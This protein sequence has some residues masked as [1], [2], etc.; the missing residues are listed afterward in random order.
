MCFLLLLLFFYISFF[1]LIFIFLFV[2]GSVVFESEK[3]HEVRWGSG[4]RESDQNIL[5]EKPSK[6]LKI[7]I[8]IYAHT[9]A[10][11][12]LTIS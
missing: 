9:I 1:V 4:E 10:S 5:Y 7:Y 11:T 8:H 6:F 12:S 2:L 3:E